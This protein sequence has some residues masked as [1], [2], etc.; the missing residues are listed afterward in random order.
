MYTLCLDASSPS[1][2]VLGS[3]WFEHR[4]R[5][6]QL[7][8]SSEVQK[9]APSLLTHLQPIGDVYA[10]ASATPLL[11]CRHEHGDI[12]E[13]NTYELQPCRDVTRSATNKKKI[14]FGSWK[15]RTAPPIL[16]KRSQ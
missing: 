14:A 7:G 5:V 6:A 13:S 8:Q 9:E 1:D 12:D 11:K 3:S 4:V 15:P 16:L 2:S 10:K